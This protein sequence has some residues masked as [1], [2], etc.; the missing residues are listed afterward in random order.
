VAHGV[1]TRCRFPGTGQGNEDLGGAA[2]ATSG[3]QVASVRQGHLWVSD[4]ASP[5]RDVADLHGASPAQTL[6]AGAFSPDG[7]MLAL[8]LSRPTPPCSAEGV[9]L[10]DV[11]TR[12]EAV[13]SDVSGFGVAWALDG[14]NL[15]VTRGPGQPPAVVDVLSHAVTTSEVMPPAGRVIPMFG[16]G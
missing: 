7:T 12:E 16:L 5:A 15:V 4:G 9:L 14:R 2:V 11:R 10:V 3:L 8:A 13:I 1:S 6:G